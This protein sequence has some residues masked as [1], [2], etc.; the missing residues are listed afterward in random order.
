VTLNG[1]TLQAGRCAAA[2]WRH[3]LNLSAVKPAQILLFD[4][5]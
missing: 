1:Q 4:L 2:K 3:A 5:N